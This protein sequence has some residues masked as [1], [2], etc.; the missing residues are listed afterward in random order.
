M[1][2]NII[3]YQAKLGS[4]RTVGLLDYIS[5][6]CYYNIVT[7]KSLYRSMPPYSLRT[8]AHT[9]DCGVQA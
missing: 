8:H 3:L 1:E 7:K 4:K 2:V 6:E 9:N 5:Y